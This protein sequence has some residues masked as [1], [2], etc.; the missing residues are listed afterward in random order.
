MADQRRLVLAPIHNEPRCSGRLEQRFPRTNRCQRS[1]F[2]DQ[3]CRRRAKVLPAKPVIAEGARR[4][5]QEQSQQVDGRRRLKL[6]CSVGSRTGC[7]WALP[8][9]RSNRN[10]V[11]A[12]SPALA[13]AVGLRWVNGQNEKNSEGV[14]AA[15]ANREI[16]QI[17]ERESGFNFRVVLVVRG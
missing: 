3:F 15:E 6:F 4:S 5:P 7:G 17:R 11:A 14:V 12:F 8:Q 13:D 10:A 16:R 1:E 9:P 2:S